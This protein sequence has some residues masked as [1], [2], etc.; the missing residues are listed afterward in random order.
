MINSMKSIKK[1][2][3]IGSIRIDSKNLT[4]Y[5]KTSSGWK[6]S[7]KDISCILDIIKL[8]KAEGRSDELINP[9]E[10][11]FLKGQLSPQG[12]AFGARINILPNGKK[13]DKA[14][15]LFSSKLTLHDQMSH[16]HWDVIYQNKG[17][18]W[19][20]L[21]T[22]DKKKN[23]SLK[24]YGKVE[25]F[26]KIYHKLMDNARKSLHDNNDFMAVPMYTLLTTH[27]S[28]GNET[29]YKA[30]GH[31]GLTTLIKKMSK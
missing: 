31:R 13:L 15:S 9:K 18:T 30:H 22:L 1:E 29:Y 16:D 5:E 20:Y 12:Q 11:K 7:K 23:H 26:E 10:K 2:T 8:Y 17:G 19:S 3:P 21:Y 4:P 27:M 28:I 24:K 6:K 25:E 14:F